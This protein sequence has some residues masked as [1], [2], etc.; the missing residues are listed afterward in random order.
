MEKVR[1]QMSW[2]VNWFNHCLR[3]WAVHSKLFR[4]TV[5]LRRLGCS[6]ESGRG[7]PHSKAVGW[8]LLTG[9]LAAKPE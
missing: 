3:H 4:D 8:A 7:L 1:R 5:R 9:A 2:R 6:E